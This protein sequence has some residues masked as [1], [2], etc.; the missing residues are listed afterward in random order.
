[1]NSDLGTI[2]WH[3]L[4]RSSN[5]GVLDSNGQYYDQLLHILGS[6]EN[7]GRLVSLN[8]RRYNIIV[9]YSMKSEAIP[10]V[11]RTMIKQ[12]ESACDTTIGQYIVKKPDNTSL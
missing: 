12:C 9:M 2:C 5:M 8:Q 10:G 3:I 4:H 1:M 7:K 6:K 11:S